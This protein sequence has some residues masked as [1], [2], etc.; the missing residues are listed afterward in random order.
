[1][2]A[3]LPRRLCHIARSGA[4]N[5]RN[6]ARSADRSA[7][8]SISAGLRIA[9]AIGAGQVAARGRRNAESLRR[10][11]VQNG[12][13]GADRGGLD[14]TANQASARKAPSSAR[15][16]AERKLNPLRFQLEP[17]WNRTGTT[18]PLISIENKSGSSGSSKS[19]RA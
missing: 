6:S 1:L 15:R 12:A 4:R 16:G 8:S 19:A 18:N 10:H 11:P 5:R 3:P 2:L 7:P 14:L 13:G 9:T 17:L